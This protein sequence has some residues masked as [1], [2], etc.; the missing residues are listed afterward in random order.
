MQSRKP[1]PNRERGAE[2]L[3]FALSLVLILLLVLGIMEF[4][5]FV[6]AYNILAGATREATRY[7][8][9]HGSKSG[10]PATAADI[11]AQV[12]HW[13]VGLDPNALTVSTTWTPANTPGST[14]Q[15]QTSYRLVPVATLILANPITIGSRS[16]LVISQ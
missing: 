5:R 13:A 8:I 9:V 6:Y 11:T 12:R 10:T 14:V 7:A 1:G 16:Q 2:T 3:E 4:G 15:V